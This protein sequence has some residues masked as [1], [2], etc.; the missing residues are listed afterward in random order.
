MNKYNLRIIVPIINKKY[1][2]FI[3]NNILVGNLLYMLVNSINE[4]YNYNLENLLLYKLNNNTN[5]SLDDYILNVI[6]NGET[7]ILK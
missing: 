7:L 4:M 3:P 5:I 1:D 2:I 6:N